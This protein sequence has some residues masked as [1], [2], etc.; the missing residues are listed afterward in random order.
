MDLTGNLAGN[1]KKFKRM[2]NNYEVRLRTKSNELRTATFLTC[3]GPDVLDIYDGLPF[4][5]D[6]EKTNIAKVLDLLEKYFIGET[7]E[8]SRSPG[9]ETYLFNKREQ[10]SGESFDAYLTNLRSLA[11][12]CNFGELRD[13][14]IRDRIVIGI[15]DNSI[16]KKL[17]AEGKLTLDKCIN[18]CRA[19]ETTAKQFKEIN[20]SEDVNA[21]T[22]RHPQRKAVSYSKGSSPGKGQR[23]TLAQPAMIKCKFCCKTHLKK[24]ES[25][26]AWQKTCKE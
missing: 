16:C 7:S 1:W 17:L 3:I 14:L 12:T 25:C 15:R 26:P 13:N 19:N 6:E 21:I 10:D 20:Q 11:K 18:I 23:S 8:T 24:K 5:N 2:W 22:H 9:Y 4:G